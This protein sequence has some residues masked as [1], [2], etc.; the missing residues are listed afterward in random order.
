MDIVMLRLLRGRTSNEV[1]EIETRAV[2]LFVHILDMSLEEKNPN[3][4]RWLEQRHGIKKVSVTEPEII[5][6]RIVALIEPVPF[7]YFTTKW[8]I[9]PT[10]RTVQF[11]ESLRSWLK[12]HAGLIT[13]PDLPLTV[14]IWFYF[15]TPKTHKS[16][17]KDHV[18]RPDIDN[19]AKATLDC[20]KPLY[21][22]RILKQEGIIPDDKQINQLI[23]HKKFTRK[24]PRIVI[25][26]SHQRIEPEL[27]QDSLL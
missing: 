22:K 18:I 9:A 25:I 26:I 13:D 17:T 20:I 15:R 10:P 3:L 4:D 11:Q 21:K 1:E 8:G 5:S 6:H 12:H 7:S 14:K 19:L 16:E 2:Q 27:I 23:L 24:T